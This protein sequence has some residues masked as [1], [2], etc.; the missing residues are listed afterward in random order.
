ML[1]PV[2][3]LALVFSSL[4]YG[5][6]TFRRYLMLQSVFFLTIESFIGRFR[7]LL[8][9]YHSEQQIRIICGVKKFSPRRYEY[10]CCIDRP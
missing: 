6:F 8:S 7:R 1:K 2:A 10:E 4:F 5:K 9:W 3:V